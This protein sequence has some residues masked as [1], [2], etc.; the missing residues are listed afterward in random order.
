MQFNSEQL[1]KASYILHEG[2]TESHEQLLLHA[3]RKQ[4]TKKTAVVD[5]T[6]VVL[7]LSVL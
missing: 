5:G 7:S 6:T 4:Q 1:D 2:R 3:N